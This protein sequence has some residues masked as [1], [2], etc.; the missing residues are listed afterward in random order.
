MRRAKSLN[1]E[2]KAVIDILATGRF[3]NQPEDPYDAAQEAI[4]IIKNI[5]STRPNILLEMIFKVS[6]SDLAIDMLPTAIACLICSS[7]SDYLMNKYVKKHIIAILIK[8][9]PSKLL[10]T[11]ELVKSK[12]FGRGMGSTAQKLF[13]KI[14]ESWDE[15]TL[16]WYSNFYKDSVKHLTKIIHPKLA[17]RKGNIV[18]SVF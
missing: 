6:R 18:K 5:A 4:N 15:S 7:P 9:G 3:D 17:G 1:K 13:K 10:E 2:D 14:I 8:F 11:V 16:I 12:V